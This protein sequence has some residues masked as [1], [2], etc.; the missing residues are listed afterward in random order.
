MT[1]NRAVNQDEPDA[2]VQKNQ[3]RVD[4]CDVNTCQHNYGKVRK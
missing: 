3:Q 4:V 2:D 1:T